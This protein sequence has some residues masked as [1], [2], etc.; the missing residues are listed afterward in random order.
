MEPFRFGAA[1]GYSMFFHSEVPEQDRALV[2]RINNEVL[3]NPT[4]SYSGKFIGI[5]NGQIVAI[6]DDQDQLDDLLDRLDLDTAKQ[7]YFQAG[8]D[9]DKV[10]YI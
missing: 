1:G 5:A 3:A 6:A 8:A 9:Y 2:E 4:S 7:F 10:E